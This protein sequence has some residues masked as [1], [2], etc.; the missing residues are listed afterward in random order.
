MFKINAVL[1]FSGHFSWLKRVF[2]YFQLSRSKSDLKYL[3]DIT[4]AIIEERKHQKTESKVIEWILLYD[5]IRLS[6]ND[7]LHISKNLYYVPF[8]STL[9]TVNNICGRSEVHMLLLLFSI[10]AYE[11]TC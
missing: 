8:Q 3:V 1:L 6:V 7:M 5:V 10:S 11:C 9:K 2:V 4:L